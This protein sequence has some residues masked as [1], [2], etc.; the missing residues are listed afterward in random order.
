[1]QLD[2]TEEQRLLAESVTGFLAKKYA[3]DK[4][5]AQAGGV[6]GFDRAIWAQFAEMGWLGIGIAEEHGGIGGGG[7]E[8]AI[9]AEGFGRHL[10]MEPYLASV[11]LGA[12]LLRDAAAGRGALLEEIASG[13]KT[14]ALAHGEPGSRYDLTHV[15]TVAE[16]KGAGFALTG[17]KAVVLNGASADRLIVS[18]RIF[19]KIRDRYGVGL[20]LVPRAAAGLSVRPYCT[21]D[22]LRAAEV[23]LDAV[24]VGAEAMLGKPDEAL[25][26]VERAVDAALVALSAEAVGAMSALIELTREY[27]RTRIQFGVPIGSFQ[28]LQHRLVDMFMAASLARSTMEIAARALDNPEEDPRVKSRLAAAA[29]VQAGRAGRLVGQEAIQM[30]GGM[31]MTEELAVGHYFKRLTMID[32]TFGNADHH[33]RRFAAL[34][35]A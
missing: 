30:H 14:V 18:A 11:V 8:T 10:V 1:M 25:G 33:Q 20:F 22:G 13:A 31:G 23:V 6:D 5:R 16:R 19:G 27:L 32:L 29:K 2:F 34:E 7:I 24:Q 3:F 15:E 12:N 9:V 26:M 21:A 17:H 4:N 28:V 35:A